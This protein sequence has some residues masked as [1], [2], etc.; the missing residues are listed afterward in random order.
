MVNPEVIKGDYK[1]LYLYSD[2]TYA[3]NIHIALY[4]TKAFYLTYEM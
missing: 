3:T 1:E 4:R 2:G